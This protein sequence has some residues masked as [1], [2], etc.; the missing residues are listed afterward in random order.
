MRLY[1]APAH[2]FTHHHK[3]GLP[4]E[5]PVLNCSITHRIHQ[6]ETERIHER[7]EFVDDEDVIHTAS[8]WLEDQDKEFFYSGIQGVEKRWDKFISVGGDYVEE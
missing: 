2:S 3:N 8:G 1:G 6:T 5:M 4:S 7:T